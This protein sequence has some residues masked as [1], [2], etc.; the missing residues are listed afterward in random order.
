MGQPSPTLR[1]RARESGGEPVELRMISA[2]SG[3]PKSIEALTAEADVVLLARLSRGKSYLS[4]AEYD[5]YTDFIIT[6]PR[7]L[8]GSL[9]SLSAAPTA[10]TPPVVT[11]RGG[12]IVIEGVPVRVINDN[13]NALVNGRYLLFLNR[14]EDVAKFSIHGR[15][16]FAI[17]E[18]LVK[19]LARGGV[20][21]FPGLKGA[22][23]DTLVSR[24]ERAAKQR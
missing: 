4:P 18:Q 22:S 5:L 12:E 10:A 3:G 9:V 2:P 23:V 11:L 7:V 6:E 15:G 21:M 13:F 19:P 20:D 1:D 17:E 24:V 8:A 16:I 14:G